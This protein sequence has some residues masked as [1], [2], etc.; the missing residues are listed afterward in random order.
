MPEQKT[1]QRLILMDGTIIEDGHCG[2]SEGHLWCW[3]TGYTMVQAA[4]IF[5]DPDKTGKIIYEYGEMSDE[6]DGYTNCTNLF[7]DYDGQVSACLVKAV[8]PN[9]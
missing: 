5:F 1:G 3:V 7:I 2:Y 8:N 9:V 4:A 6:Y